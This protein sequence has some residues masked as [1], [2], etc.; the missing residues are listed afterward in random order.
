MDCHKSTFCR[1]IRQGIGY[2]SY[3][4]SH[5][6][7]IK[8]ASKKSKKVKALALLNELRHGSVGMPRFFSDEKNFDQDKMSNR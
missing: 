3:R 1:I 7:L 5:C 8:E 6:M 4:K 2:S